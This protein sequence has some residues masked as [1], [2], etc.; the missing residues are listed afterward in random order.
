MPNK[1]REERNACSRRYRARNKQK[2]AD[3]NKSEPF[4]QKRRRWMQE[5]SQTQHFKDMRKRIGLNWKS[6]KIR[7]YPWYF[8]LASARSR[9]SQ[10]GIP[11]NL[12]YEWAEKRWTGVCEMTGIPFNLSENRK[13]GPYSPSLDRIVPTLGYVEDNC[14]FVLFGVNLL[15]HVGTDED[16]VHIANAIV[17][18]SST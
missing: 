9:C 6:K 5:Y 12:T 15:K 14:R 7:E 2:I 11:F 1:D 10:R 8:I 3:R 4:K 13:Q 16:V 17:A 18:A